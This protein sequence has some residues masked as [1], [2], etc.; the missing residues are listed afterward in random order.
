M[1]NT[2]AYRWGPQSSRQPDDYIAVVMLKYCKDIGA[3]RILDVGCGNGRMTS[4][5]VGNGFDVEGCDVSSE[6]IELARSQYPGVPFH[7][8]GVYE[9]PP[10]SD[11]DTVVSTEVIEHLYLPRKLIQF[12]RKALKPD[13][14][15]VITAPYHGYLKNLVL[16]LSGK[17]DPHFQPWQDGGHIKF[18]SRASLTALV[19]SEGFRVVG[20]SGAGRCTYL[21]KSMVLLCRS[22]D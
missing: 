15:L 9:E 7:K 19:E 11:F 8:I 22:V 2:A 21:W 12:A 17:W 4:V 1:H 18:F 6:G 10:S 13:G 16:S 14:N 20:F 5:L 3:R